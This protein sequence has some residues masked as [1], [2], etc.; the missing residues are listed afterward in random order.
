MARFS[1]AGIEAA[2]PNIDPVFCRSPQFESEPL[3]QALGCRVVLK[4]ET[5][6]PVR[7]FKGRGADL[8]VQRAEG[9]L[10]C[11]SAGNFGQAVAYAARKYKLPVTIFAATGANP[12]KVQRMRELGATVMLCGDDFDAAKLAG[13]DYA[14]SQNVRW[15]EDGLDVETAI[16]AGTIG[17]ELARAFPDLHAWIIP[18]GN[19]ALVNGMGCVAKALVPSAAVVGVQAAGAPAMIESWRA[20]KLIRYPRTDTTADG[21]AVREPVPEALDDLAEVLDEGI[22][23]S[24]ESIAEAMRLL[25]RVA[26]LVTEPAGA[27]GIAALLENPSR[28]QRRRVAVP[29]CGSNVTTEQM[30]KWFG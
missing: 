8:L 19:G 18:V 10:V 30:Q 29:I 24:E 25:F 20:K 14:R 9:P 26:G 4:I 17:L 22:L 6:N 21:I 15:V 23:V 12:F 16:G 3:G 5:M 7:C 28:F 13:R 2:A 27:A 1:V 11:A